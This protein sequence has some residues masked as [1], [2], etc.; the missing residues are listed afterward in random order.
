MRIE[1]KNGKSFALIGN[2]LGHSLSPA[3]HKELFA[4]SGVSASYSLL[5]IEP[6]KLPAAFDNELRRLNGFNVTIPHK[7][8]VIPFLDGLSPR[9]ALFGSVNTVENDNGT[10]KGHN[11][12]CSGFLK[13]LDMAEIELKGSVLILGAGGVAR[14]FA[15]ESALAGADITLAVR[16]PEKAAGLRNEL[17]EKLETETKLILLDEVGGGYDL[18][19]NATP[20]GMFPN[21]QAAPISEEAVKNSG[22]VFDS[23]Y[24]P[25][26][27]LLLKY[28]RENSVKHSNGLS[29]LVWQAA[30]AE[31]IWNGVKFENDDITK[32][33][34]GLENE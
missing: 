25:K 3:I 29:M 22:A 17:K 5:E 32:V 14:T 12:D 23:I 24:N 30:K 2:P 20:C 18:I 11:T 34:R 6:E 1:F 7:L 9:A 13:A 15:F 8:A 31:E 28:A 26:E 27:T 16:N 21:V 4:L 19:I 10:L 33:I